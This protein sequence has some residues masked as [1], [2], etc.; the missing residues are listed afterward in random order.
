MIDQS[1][2]VTPEWMKQQIEKKDCYNRDLAKYLGVSD[3]QVS[4]WVH[5][6]RNPSKAAKAAIY[7]FLKD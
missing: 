3:I 5:G 7:H 4:L 1:E 6:K 2:I